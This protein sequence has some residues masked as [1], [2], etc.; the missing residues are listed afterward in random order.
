LQS[1]S[2][3]EGEVLRR[4]EESTPLFEPFFETFSRFGQV[5]SA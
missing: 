5:S 1:L 2:S 4:A 3:E